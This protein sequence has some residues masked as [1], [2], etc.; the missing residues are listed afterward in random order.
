MGLI[1]ILIA[2]NGLRRLNLGG[3]NLT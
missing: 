1:L 2:R 3:E